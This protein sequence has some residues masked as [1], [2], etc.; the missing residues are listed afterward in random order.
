MTGKKQKPLIIFP[1]F[2]ALA[3]GFTIKIIYLFVI[4]PAV[5]GD[6]LLIARDAFSYTNSFINLINTGEYTHT[7]GYEP[8]SYGRLPGIPFIWGFFYLLFGIP[9][10]YTAFALF[11]IVLDLFAGVMIFKIIQNFFDQRTALIVVWCYVM[12]P[13]NTYFVVRTDV[14]YLSLFSII[15]VFHQLVFLKTNLKQFIL[16]GVSLVAAFFIRETLILLTPIC[17]FYLARNYKINL[18]YYFSLILVM[19]VLYLPWPIRNYIRS[20]KIVLVKPLSAGYREYSGDILGYMSWIYSWH[21]CDAEDC[22]IYIYDLEKEI[23]FPDE[24]FSTPT[25]KKIATDLVVLAQRKG[26]GFSI[27]RNRN[28]PEKID[29][30]GKYD[31]LINRGFDLLEHN[32][33]ATHPFTYYVKIP[34]QNLSKAFFKNSLT[35]EGPTPPLIF[36]VT[37]IVRTFLVLLGIF[38]CFY[39]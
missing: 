22:W 18:K 31:A 6:D 12:F 38:S 33:K 20:D 5:Y 9:K 1:L 2:I 35:F 17:F 32:F 7:P 23:H 34:L 10:A 8:A 24:I 21:N 26:S 37:M 15:L 3:V 11:Q 19:F 28:D 30:S 25:E 4:G 16:L 14:D 29:S 27:W 13:L 39:Y 36:K